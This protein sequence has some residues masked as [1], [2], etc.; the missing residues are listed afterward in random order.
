MLTSPTW[1]ELRMLDDIVKNVTITYG[2]DKQ[3]YTY[4]DIC[5]R[6]MDD[7]FEN[8]ILNLDSV[9]EQVESK[10]LN[11]TFPAMINPVTWDA[12]VF[13]SFFGR[14]VR[15]DDVIERVPSVQLMYFIA[16][17]TKIDDEK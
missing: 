4:K 16:D 2:D 11:L 9:I 15:Q 5:A 3:T 12:H 6:W 7:C 13:P 10:Q 8:D 14:T 17:D 1:T